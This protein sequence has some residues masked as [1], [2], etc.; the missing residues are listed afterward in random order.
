MVTPGPVRS[1]GRQKKKSESVSTRVLDDPLR[2]AQT[3]RRIRLAEIRVRETS[4]L[5]A[6]FSLR[7]WF[8]RRASAC[9]VHCAALLRS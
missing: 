2:D 1:K 7:I 3:L 9:L 4:V 6:S 5:G 8:L